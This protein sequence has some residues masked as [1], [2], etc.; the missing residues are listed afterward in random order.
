MSNRRERV[1]TGRV[2]DSARDSAR[3]ARSA[4]SGTLP[5][6]TGR[7]GRSE[8]T[9][10][11]SAPLSLRS[12]RSN[13]SDGFGTERSDS[14]N[15]STNE[16][17]RR[18]REKS[19]VVRAARDAAEI[20]ALGDYNSFSRP[21]NSKKLPL[22]SVF[23]DPEINNFPKCRTNSELQKRIRASGTPHPSYDLDGDGYVSQ[24]D[25]RLAKRFDFDGNGVLDPEERKIGQ[26][27]LAEEFFRRHTHDI[28]KFGGKIADRDHTG[29]VD[30]LVNAYSFERAYDKLL[31][32][33]RTLVAESSAPIMD[34]MKFCGGDHI[35]QHN[36]YT[37]KFDATAYNDIE[38][39]PRATSTLQLDDHGGSRSRLLFT[40]KEIMRCEN[41]DK[42]DRIIDAKPM[43][44]TRR[45]S[46][47]TNVAIENS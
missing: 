10:A 41:Q 33:E 30:A 19:D 21:R 38:A 17:L 1:P 23:L 46:L 16:V 37:N 2:N 28:S 34:C 22:R 40:R 5:P 15:I 27:V 9:S 11:R 36:F 43:Q 18:M 35:L 45:R 20:E 29:N 26:R 25:Y 39:V 13:L 4:G 32:K 8:I 42:L 44:Q 14:S 12:A 47:I 7:T 6:V 24:E 3:S 31:E